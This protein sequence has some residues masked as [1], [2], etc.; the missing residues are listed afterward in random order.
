MGMA[1]PQAAEARS[2][3]LDLPARRLRVLVL[4][5]HV[6]QYASPT[7]RLLASD[8]RLDILVAYCSLQGAEPGWDPEFGVEVQWDVPLLDGYPWIHV[9]N[10]S[11]R[12]R[13]GH[14]FGLLNP[15]LWKHIRTGRFDAVVTYTGYMCASFWIAW[16][17]AKIQRIP[18]MISADSTTLQSREGGRWRNLVKPFVLRRVF[19][20]VDFIMAVSNAGKEL[21]NELGVDEQCVQVIRS[22][23][24]KEAWLARMQKTD[25]ATVRQSLGIPAD[26]PVVFYCAKLQAWKRPLDLLRAF[27]EAKIPSAHLVFAGEGPQRKELEDQVHRLGVADRVHVL[28]FVN[29]SRLPGLYQAADLFVLPSEYD[30]C[31][32]VVAEAMFSG[33]PVVMSDAVR[34]RLEMID[35][36]KSGYVYPCGDV[37]AL[38]AILEQ[39]LGKREA[40][41]SL[42]AGVHRQMESWTR[43]D[44]LDSWITA[45]KTAVQ[46]K[47]N[48]HQLSQ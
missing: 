5:T 9:R 15:G 11:L 26:T 17:A 41:E 19:S 36:G 37:A 2:R 10:R 48:S 38:A 30:P 13:L 23:M 22:G 14:F 4:A 27:V 44:F 20:S 33:L 8:P 31:P 3:V 18:F 34:G 28:G 6:V 39:T 24:D 16:L 46:Q 42:K 47:Q 45:V 21:A 7:F 43:E 40:L 32:L 35:E 1:L 25:P 29:V 12:P